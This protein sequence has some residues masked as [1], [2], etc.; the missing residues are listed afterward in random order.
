MITSEYE[1]KIL[2]QSLAN[3]FLSE[4]NKAVEAGSDA[5]LV[6]DLYT[7]KLALAASQMTTE[8]QAAFYDSY[9]EEMSRV[10]GGDGQAAE[11]SSTSPNFDKPKVNVDRM[12]VR[13]YVEKDCAALRECAEKGGNVH[14]LSLDQQDI[15]DGH[16]ANLSDEEK[17]AFLDVYTQEMNA[18]NAHMVSET[19]RLNIQT[20]QTLAKIES[21]R[22]AAEAFGKGI[23]V[24]II[25]AI[26][27]FFVFR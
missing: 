8:I 21:D 23:G 3:E 15:L 9:S 16:L 12:A 24:L 11:V 10:S 18:M 4:L 20:E 13:S 22:G 27:L 1:A 5:V 25:F 17:V 7:A 26:V 14:Q 19:D 6:S 2:G